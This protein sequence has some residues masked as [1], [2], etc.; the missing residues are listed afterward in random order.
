MM[1]GIHDKNNRQRCQHKMEMLSHRIF[2]VNESARAMGV[3][4]NISTHFQLLTWS[5]DT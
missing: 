5:R 4:A 2:N 3:P 1:F